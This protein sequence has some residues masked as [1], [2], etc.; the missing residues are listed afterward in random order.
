MIMNDRN[1]T[2]TTCSTTQALL[3]SRAQ[4]ESRT[5]LIRDENRDGQMSK[6][7]TASVS[8]GL[9]DRKGETER[10][11]SLWSRCDRKGKTQ[12]G[13]LDS[14]AACGQIP[15]QTDGVRTGLDEQPVIWLCDGWK[16]AHSGGRG[17]MPHMEPVVEG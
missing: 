7:K 9:R 5:Y 3:K 4:S 16:V 11:R 12:R 14:G 15:L 2:Q 6:Q 17:E 8:A 10:G 13:L 1:G